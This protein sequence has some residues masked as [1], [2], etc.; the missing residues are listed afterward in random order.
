[1]GGYGS[2]AWYRWNT[3]VLV[4]SCLSLDV[5]YLNREG[6]LNPGT[7]GSLMW[8]HETEHQASI[9]FRVD[10]DYLV[11]QYHL[12]EDSAETIT[13]PVP[14]AWTAC[15]YGGRRP[16][17]R[18]PG[19]AN[20]VYCG[21]RV[22]KLYILSRYFVCRNCYPLAYPSQRVAVAHRP[23]TRTQNIRIRLGGSGNLLEPFPPKPKGM[24]WKVYWRWWDKARNAET[25]HLG[26]MQR[27]LDR[28]TSARVGVNRRADMESSSPLDYAR[29][30]RLGCY[31]SRL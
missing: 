11:L 3:K 29:T 20:G 1:M 17:F 7:S 19:V 18:C 26:I 30:C 5:S 6:L 12:R 15:H 8:G 10:R 31:T 21:R 22:A 4:T 14:L 27:W 9:Q 28:L 25:E 2:G 24:R 23:M 13:Q 16:W